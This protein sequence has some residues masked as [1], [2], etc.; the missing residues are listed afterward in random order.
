MVPAEDKARNLLLKAIEMDERGK[1]AGWTS[2]GIKV[3][4]SEAYTAAAEA[5]KS[6][7]TGD[8]E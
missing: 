6:D 2:P 7:G 1:R 8:M 5:R 3:R 4:V